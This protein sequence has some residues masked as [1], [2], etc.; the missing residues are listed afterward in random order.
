MSPTTVPWSVVTTVMTALSAIWAAMKG[1][2]RCVGGG[3]PEHWLV[4]GLV[5]PCGGGD[6]N[7]R[8]EVSGGRGAG[9]HRAIVDRIRGGPVRA[10]DATRLFVIP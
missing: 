3:V 1:R 8:V 7:D 5:G 10:A 6:F 2:S 9:R 4:D